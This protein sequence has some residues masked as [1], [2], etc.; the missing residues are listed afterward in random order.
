M[1]ISVETDSVR[2][3][4]SV[5]VVLDIMTSSHPRLISDSFSLA[6]RFLRAIPALDGWEDRMKEINTLDNRCQSLVKIHDTKG[7]FLVAPDI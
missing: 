7:K 5:A 6:V 3:F 2:H 1:T 4:L